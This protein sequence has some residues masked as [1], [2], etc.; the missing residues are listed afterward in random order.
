MGLF[1]ARLADAAQSAK[2]GDEQKTKRAEPRVP[3]IVPVRL[4]SVNFIC[5]LIQNL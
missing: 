5:I 3:T 4:I 2:P 1:G